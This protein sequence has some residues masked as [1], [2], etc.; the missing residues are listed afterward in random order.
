MAAPARVALQTPCGGGG[1][2]GNG[3]RPG[4]QNGAGGEGMCFPL[5]FVFVFEGEEDVDIRS[6]V[7]LVERGNGLCGK[8]RV[9]LERR[10][11]LNLWK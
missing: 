2:R 7:R 6:D 4:S 8:N 10:R 3:R 11:Y 5:G 1:G 9:W